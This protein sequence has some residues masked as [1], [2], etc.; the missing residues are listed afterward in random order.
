MQ[1]VVPTTAGASMWDYALQWGVLGIA[2]LVF[3]LVIRHLYARREEDHAAFAAERTKM[4]EASLRKD[5]DHAAELAR[6][7]LDAEVKIREATERYAD[8]VHADMQESRAREDSIRREF[9]DLMETIASKAA[10]ASDATRQV[11]DKIYERFLGPRKP[12]Y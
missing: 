1:Q 5:A 8:A 12:G 10:E 11:L 3:A 2:V 4:F 6:I 9:S 7:R